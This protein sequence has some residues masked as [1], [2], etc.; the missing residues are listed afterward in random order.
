M[1]SNG[2]E[3]VMELREER[4]GFTLYLNFEAAYLIV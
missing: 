1:S 4:S 2:P 3:L